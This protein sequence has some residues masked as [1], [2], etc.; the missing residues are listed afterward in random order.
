[1][2]NK[3]YSQR[4]EDISVVNSI[5]QSENDVKLE[6]SLQ[7]TDEAGKAREKLIRQN[8]NLRVANMILKQEL[9]QTRGNMLSYEDSIS[10][11]REIK[12]AFQSSYDSY[13]LM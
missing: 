12:R 1:M 13:A 2:A 11:A 3:D 4:S 10:L 6:Y 9:V 8:K 7:S 5:S